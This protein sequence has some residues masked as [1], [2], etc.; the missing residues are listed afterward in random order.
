M[1]EC[2]GVV[3]GVF[4]NHIQPFAESG[5]KT[6]SLTYRVI[7][8][9][10][11]PTDDISFHVK[12]IAAFLDMTAAGFDKRSIITVGDKAYILTVRFVRVRESFAVCQLAYL[13]FCERSERKHKTTQPFTTQ[14]IKNITLILCGVK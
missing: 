2:D 11:M 8:D 6:T 14:G 12:E 13:V 9:S 3:S 10:V 4:G 7:Q 5:F 1:A